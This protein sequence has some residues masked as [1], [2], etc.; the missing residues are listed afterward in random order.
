MASNNVYQ[1]NIVFVGK[2]KSVKLEVAST[3]SGSKFSAASIKLTFEKFKATQHRNS[4]TKN[5]HSIW[6][7]FNDFVIRLDE[8]SR[9]WEER[10]ALYGT[11]LVA[12]GVQLAT[13]KSYK[14]AIKNILVTDGY[15]WND[16]KVMLSIL[17][18]AC[19]IKNDILTLRRPIRLLL[20][21]ILLFEMECLF[22]GNQPQPYL[23]ALYKCMFSLAYYGLMRVGE[24]TW[25][26]HV[27]KAKDIHVA[28]NKNKMLIVLYSSKT[29]GKESAPQEIKISE[30]LVGSNRVRTRNFCPFQVTR[31]YMAY[32]GHYLH[33]VDLF[34]IF[35]D[36]TP[37][38]PNN[39]R[40]TLHKLIL[41]VDLDPM[42]Y[43][44]HSMR[45]THCSDLYDAGYDLEFLKKAGRW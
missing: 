11:Y 13:L 4:T 43:N 6:R 19:R 45:A 20:L 34:F 31:D 14:S 26:P 27:V 30:S 24:L 17:V 33:D 7:Q 1:C 15:P 41:G 35:K 39:M 21:E 28:R 10:M 16:D 29:H 38:R 3:L 22:G 40:N 2:A 37:V 8:P 36:R 44:T 25:S 32:R 42:W 5:Y 9:T 23:E 12:K 18:K